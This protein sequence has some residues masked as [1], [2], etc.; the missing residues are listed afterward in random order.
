[1]YDD[2]SIRIRVNETLP[3]G[4]WEGEREKVSRFPDGDY[5]LRRERNSLSTK[6][7]R[8]FFEHLLLIIIK[9]EKWIF[10]RREYPKV[11]DV[12]EHK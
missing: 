4:P 11:H 8:S 7:V 12:R 10:G 5:P 2:V 9:S 1:V 3:D 6:K